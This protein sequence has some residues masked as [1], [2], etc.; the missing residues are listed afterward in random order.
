MKKVNNVMAKFTFDTY[1]SLRKQ[2]HDRI[3]D[4]INAG[5][6]DDI[7]LNDPLRFFEL[8]RIIL[9]SD[10]KLYCAV[11]NYGKMASM[12]GDTYGFI[13]VFSSQ[14]DKID[15]IINAWRF[16]FLSVFIEHYHEF[17]SVWER[18]KTSNG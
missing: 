9:E 10:R 16:I 6:A 14:E 4:Y 15:A 11:G 1:D 12:L 8:W 17:K 18:R 2:V 5:Q 3:I 13:Y 7:D